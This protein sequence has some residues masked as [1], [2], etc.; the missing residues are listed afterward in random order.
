MV[1]GGQAEV[2]E[3]RSRGFAGH[4]YAFVVLGGAKPHF[5]GPFG[6]EKRLALTHPLHGGTRAILASERDKCPTPVEGVGGLGVVVYARHAAILLAL[7]DDQTLAGPRRHAADVD[8]GLAI[9]LLVMRLAGSRC[10]GDVRAFVPHALGGAG[11]CGRRCVSGHGGGLTRRR[12]LFVLRLVG[13]QRLEH[14]YAHP[15]GR[16]I[17]L[18]RRYRDIRRGR[19]RRLCRHSGLRRLHFFMRWLCRRRQLRRLGLRGQRRTNE[20]SVL[21]RDAVD[22]TGTI[23]HLRNRC[24]GGACVLGWGR[25]TA[26]PSYQ[27]RGATQGLVG[28]VR[29]RGHHQRRGDSRRD[30]RW[31]RNRGG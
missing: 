26:A 15:V 12:V 9:F 1:L 8:L 17:G 7:G 16:S 20:V 30:T 24:K 5:H 27:H 10:A 25:A 19:C 13:D 31:R 29:G 4:L 21:L 14:L 2:L 23:V 3:L 18:V 22:K 28:S 11:R 6:A